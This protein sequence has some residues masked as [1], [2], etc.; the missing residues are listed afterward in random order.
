MTWT[1]GCAETLVAVGLVIKAAHPAL[2][3]EAGRVISGTDR[4]LVISLVTFRGRAP[5]STCT[6]TKWPHG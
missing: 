3:Y 1:G 5:R 6:R 4:P 2:H